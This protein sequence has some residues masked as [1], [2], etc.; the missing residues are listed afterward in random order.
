MRLLH[1]SSFFLKDFPGQT[2][3]AYAVLSHRWRE[4]EVLYQ[5]IEDDQYHNKA[6]FD[7]V[8]GFCNQSASDGFEWVWIDTCCIN[9]N[10]S[11]ELSEAINSMFRWYADAG[12]CYAYLD[13]VLPSGTMISADV[14]RMS[15]TVLQEFGESE[16]FTRGWTLQELIAPLS[17]EF[18]SKK[19]ISIGTKRSLQNEL[20]TIT[21]I[22][23]RVFRG[24]D[25]KRYNVCGKNVMGIAAHY[26]QNRRCS[27]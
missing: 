27:L 1:S 7:K 16:W 23:I 20:S 13:D 10:S 4:E 21:G 8:K 15:G 18:Y 11:A 6:G 2:I 14:I 9:K 25:P 19:W 24:R 17:V 26:H 3:P 22:D 5:D 12:K